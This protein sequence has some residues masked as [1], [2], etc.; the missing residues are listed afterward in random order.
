MISTPMLFSVDVDRLSKY[1]NNFL[2]S[3]KG[4]DAIQAGELTSVSRIT[5]AILAPR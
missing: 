3:S 4:M 2:K 5:M 1:N